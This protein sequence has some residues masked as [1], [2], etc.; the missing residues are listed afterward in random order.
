MRNYIKLMRPKHYIKNFLIFFPLVFSGNFFQKELLGSCIMCFFAFCLSASIVYII[1]DIKD[2]EKD[3]LHEKKKNRPIASGKVSVKNAIVLAILLFF[4]S[5]F[6][7]VLA[8]NKLLDFSYLYILL[9]IILNIGYSLGLKNVPL[10]DVAILV[11][12][13]LIRV[14]YGASIVDVEISNWLYLTVISAAFYLGFG[15]RRNEIKKVGNKSREVL[16]YYNK[17][18]LDKNMYMCLSLTIV[19]YALWTVDPINVVK[20]SNMLVWTVPFIM[21]ILMKYS[22]NIENDSFGDPVNVVLEDKVLIITII[23]Y[24]I[25]VMSLIYF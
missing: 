3:K 18:F 9:Y 8:S 23:L 5:Y 15:K 13:F 17:D 22:M 11:S 4:L 2:K 10:L 14:L 7:Q 24:G 20:A 16:K 19:F 12:G 25:T 21:L 6:F 1:N